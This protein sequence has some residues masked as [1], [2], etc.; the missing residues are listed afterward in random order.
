M[1]NPGGNQLDRRR[2]A[3]VF[4]DVANYSRMMSQD[5]MTTALAV[6]GRIALFRTE[7]EEFSGELVDIAGD[8]VFLIFDEP[9][10]AVSFA[11]SIQKKLGAQNEGIEASKQIW[12]RVGINV[13]D[14]LVDGTELSGD[15]INIASR[16]EAFAQP[17]R[18]CISGVTYEEV[19]EKLLLGYEY[20]GAQEFKNI[21]KSVDVFQV[22]E[23]PHSA[24]MTSGL[25]HDRSTKLSEIDRELSIVVL[26][27]SYQG[28]EAHES[29]FA[30]GLTEDITTN[31]SRFHEFF[32]IS[33]SSA[34]VFRDKSMP[35]ARVGGELGVR[36]VVDGSVRRA[37]SRIRVAIQLVDAVRERTIWGEQYN[38]DVEDLFDLQ[39]EIT[40]VI[41]S[42][43][44]SKIRASEAERFRLLPPGSLEAYGFVLRGQSHVTR[45][46]QADV[47]QARGLYNAA[48]SNDPKYARA[49][50][51]K[52]RTLNLDWRYNWTPEPE[53]ALNDAFS[54]AQSAV[55]LDA[56][57]ARGFGELGFAHLY[58][59]ENDAAISAYNR[60]TQLNPNDADLMS[61]MA[62]AMVHSGRAEDA[63]ELLSKAMRLNPF[64]PDQYLWHLGGAY[65]HTRQYQQA[66]DTIRS[67]QNPT[68]GRRILAA[69]YGHLGL[70]TRQRRRPRTFSRRIRTSLW[71][72]GLR[73]S[74]TSLKMTPP[75]SSKD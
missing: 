16:I 47:R 48:L 50:S 13:G 43:T 26:P 10:D 23:D 30:D 56:S 11:V 72:V 42:A 75:I 58:R 21:G 63:I 61:D 6:K 59:K 17:G 62:D 66:I 64:F 15:S 40:Q 7:V 46:T 70:K 44:A 27:F 57:D 8:G 38:R 41:V 60:A 9:T 33:R 73:S 36:Y 14:I 67:M 3:I 65:F 35:P 71:I 49:L 24:T 45:Y 52:S 22:H 53:T 18:V 19:S 32:V 1:Q 29:W 74:P 39:D 51:A 69:C 31:L 25:R 2:A 12:F 68:E 4:A 5:E 37:G 55:E 28:A 54:L 34:Y 20:L